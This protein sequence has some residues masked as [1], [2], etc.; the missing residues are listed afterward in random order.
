MTLGGFFTWTERQHERSLSLLSLGPAEHVTGSSRW[1]ENNADGALGTFQR[2]YHTF[3]QE[4]FTAQAVLY[5]VYL[6][7]VLTVYT[8]YNVLKRESG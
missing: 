5:N 1:T 2:L 6:C 4:E 7:S 8:D 3:I